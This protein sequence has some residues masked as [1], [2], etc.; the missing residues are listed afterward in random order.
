MPLLP[1]SAE[2][3]ARFLQVISG[4]VVC[5]Y[6]ALGVTVGPRGLGAVAPAAELKRSAEAVQLGFGAH[7]EG[8]QLVRELNQVFSFFVIYIAETRDV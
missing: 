4:D 1:L 5:L 6:S 7:V 2:W 8:D 3:S